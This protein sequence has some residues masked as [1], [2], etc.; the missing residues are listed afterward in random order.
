MAKKERWMLIE[1]EKFDR[2]GCRHLSSFKS[3]RKDSVRIITLLQAQEGIENVIMKNI[4]IKYESGGEGRKSL[5]S[6][7]FEFS[8]ILLVKV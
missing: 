5:E 4:N 8:V 3:N 1:M 2:A 7:T 6:S